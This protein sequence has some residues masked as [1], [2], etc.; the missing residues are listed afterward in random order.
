M[1]ETKCCGSFRD[2]LQIGAAYNDIDVL[3]EPPG[4]RLRFLDV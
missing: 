2:L 4:I 1:L 3:R